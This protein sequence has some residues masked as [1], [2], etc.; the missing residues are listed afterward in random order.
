MAKIIREIP[1]G[2]IVLLRERLLA[3]E[4]AQSRVQAWFEANCQTHWLGGD[5]EANAYSAP[6]AWA[7]VLA[8]RR[9]LTSD[10]IWLCDVLLDPAIMAETGF[11]AMLA[12]IDHEK[13]WSDYKDNPKE[14]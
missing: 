6:P 13:L 4:V 7:D 11:A 10:R 9:L 2:Q 12:M 5:Q 8:D 1:P 14:Q 3:L